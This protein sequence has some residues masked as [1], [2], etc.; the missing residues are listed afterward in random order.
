MLTAIKGIYEN[1]RIVLDEIPPVQ[2]RTEVVVTFLENKQ[3]TKRNRRGGSMAGEVW[4]ANDF[5]AP[6]EDLNDYM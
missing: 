2:E 3:E 1:G 6:L 4:M 5:N